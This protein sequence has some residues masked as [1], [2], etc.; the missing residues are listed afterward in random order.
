LISQLLI[1]QPFPAGVGVALGSARPVRLAAM[2][3]TVLTWYGARRARKSLLDLVRFEL[4]D[5]AT[6][7]AVV[8]DKFTQET[9]VRPFGP[10]ADRFG[11]R[12]HVILCAEWTQISRRVEGEA[13]FRELG[14]PA[15]LRPRLLRDE[16]EVRCALLLRRRQPVALLDLYFVERGPPSAAVAD[17]GRE[18]FFTAREEL[19]AQ[20]IERLLAQPA[21]PPV[22]ANLPVEAARLVAAIPGARVSQEPRTA[23]AAGTGHDYDQTG[24]CRRCG[25]AR[26]S[27]RACPGP[28]KDEGPRRDRFELI[29]LE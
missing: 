26:F 19:A 1:D 3:Y 15:D 4:T 22:E 11:E 28:P 23:L 29:E 14:V 18:P 27:P 20:E 8:E 9:H 13:L 5:R 21:P 10:L 2:P 24:K 25:D 12:L 17:D 16:G 7:L 6:L